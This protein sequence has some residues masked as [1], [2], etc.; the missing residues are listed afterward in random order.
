MKSRP[1]SFALA[2]SLLSAVALR[3]SSSSSAT[4]DQSC[5]LGS[6]QD[7]T[8]LD[9]SPGTRACEAS[10]QYGACVCHGGEAGAAGD[11][12]EAGSPGS[13]GSG[14]GGSAAGGEGGSPAGTNCILDLV[15]GSYNSCALRN[16]QTVW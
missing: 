1:A 10:G 13:G 2:L 7:C 6:R 9:G 16:D 15:S 4:H 5:A 14:T 8:C 11:S 12:G 3:C